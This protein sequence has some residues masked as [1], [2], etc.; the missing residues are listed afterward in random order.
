MVVTGILLSF[1]FSGVLMAKAKSHSAAA[2]W[3][4]AAVNQLTAITSVHPSHSHSHIC[5]GNEPDMMSQGASRHLGQGSESIISHE[6][7]HP[8]QNIFFFFFTLSKCMEVSNQFEVQTIA[9]CI[10]VF[11]KG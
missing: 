1:L 3:E 11:S 2:H 4:T 6:L 8:P 9:M 10:S 5:L 7:L